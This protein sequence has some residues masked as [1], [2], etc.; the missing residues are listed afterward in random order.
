MRRHKVSGVVMDRRKLSAF[1]PVQN[2]EDIIIDCLDSII[3]VDE[4]FI[5]DSFSTDKT[6]EI[7]KRY[8]NVKL[9]QH[10]YINSM[11][12]R[13]WG[14][15][16]VAYNWVFIIDSDE[17]CTPALRKEIEQILSSDEISYD[18]FLVHIRTEFMAKLLKHD[19]YLGSGG[20]RLVRKEM[21]RNF[22]QKQVHSGMRIDNKTWI[23][24][25]QA[26]LLHVPIRDLSKHWQKMI[27][28]ANWSAIDMKSNKKKVNIFHFTIRPWFK[29][30]QYYIIR[31]GI[32]DGI[33]GLII[34]LFAGFSVFM[35]YAKLWELYQKNEK[36]DS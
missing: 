12:Q 32:L 29:F 27:R 21:H 10:E 6:V 13:M 14:M 20:K 9:V 16:Q 30:F 15:P 2:V 25:P 4:V 17:Q 24:N 23:K 35:K 26:Y 3:W 7:C 5:V 31:G 34:C 22:K 33:R 1:L 8:P 36:A 11:E 18:G 28:Y 19:T